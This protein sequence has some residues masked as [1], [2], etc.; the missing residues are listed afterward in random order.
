MGGMCPNPIERFPSRYAQGR[1]PH[2]V[3]PSFRQ[4]ACLSANDR[5]VA[6]L[7]QLSP[8]NAHGCGIWLDIRVTKHHIFDLKIG[9]SVYKRRCFA[10]GRVDGSAGEPTKKTNIFKLQREAVT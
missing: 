1:V 8:G 5:L 10:D 4:G 6:V 2:C 3:R 9:M 7:P